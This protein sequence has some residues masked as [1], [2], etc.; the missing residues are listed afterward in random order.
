MLSKCIS[1][2]LLLKNVH[3]PTHWMLFIRSRIGHTVEML[4]STGSAWAALV[5]G[6]GGS[7]H[8]LQIS[9]WVVGFFMDGASAQI[10]VIMGTISDENP[11]GV[12]KKTGEKGKAFQT[13]RR[14][15]ELFDTQA[16]RL[17]RL[18]PESGL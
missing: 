13:L 5:G 15:A 6:P 7:I 10:P 11:K 9:S 12:Y 1:I 14:R 18:K 2:R 17:G 4:D 3:T 16:L 8:Q